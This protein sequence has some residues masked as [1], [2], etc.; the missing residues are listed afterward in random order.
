MLRNISH[1]NIT[2]TPCVPDFVLGENEV[3]F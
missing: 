2:M 1:G 3:Q